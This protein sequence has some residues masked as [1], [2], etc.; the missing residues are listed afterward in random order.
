MNDHDSTNASPLPPLGLDFLS[1]S[2]AHPV[3]HIEAAEANGFTS[4][5]LRLVAPV[6]LALAHDI[7][8][9]PEL[10]RE[11]LAALKSTGIKV[12]DVEAFTLTETTD[13]ADLERA[14][15][16]AAELGAQIVQVVVEDSNIGRARDRFAHMCALAGRYQMI[17]AL[18]FM[19]WR[20]LKSLAAAWEFIAGAAQ[21]NGA[22]CIDS[23]HLSRCGDGPDDV[24]A[25]PSGSVGYVQLCDAVANLPP[26]EKYLTEARGGRLYPGEGELW[27]QEMM[28]VLPAEVPLSIEVPREID[29]GKS[30][31]ERARQAADAMQRFFAQRA[32]RR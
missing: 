17:V 32:S 2:G 7:V 15:A 13:V 11:T 8:N 12:L 27:L 16:V 9:R 19:K 29:A 25:L 5:G 3:D 20:S 18:E 23:L 31:A 21:P 4:V 28:D 10:L 30:V 14:F 24:A 26:P 1:V 22:L 6:G